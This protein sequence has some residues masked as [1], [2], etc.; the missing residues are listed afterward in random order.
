MKIILSRKGFDST[1][2]GII[3]PIMPDGTLL[4]LPI[5]SADTD[6]YESLIYK[7]VKYSKLL[8]DLG[9]KGEETC[10][11]DPDIRENVRKV[12]IANWQPAFGQIGTAQRYLENSGV[13]VGDLF[14]FFGCFRR[15]DLKAGKYTYVRKNQSNFYLGHPVQIIFGYLEVGKIIKEPELIQKYSWHPHSSSGRLDKQTNVLYIPS[16][17]LSFANHLPGYGVLDYNKKR[18]LTKEGRTPAKWERKEFLMPN[19]IR[20]NRKNSG[21]ADELYYGGQWQELVINESEVAS[22]WAYNIIT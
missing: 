16:K 20:G 11:L 22:K 21:A 4:S 14:L 17:Q 10:H 5:T 8:N 1:A 2:G 6:T 3:N 13:T 9:Y 7:G 19:H 15:I 12:E 18:I